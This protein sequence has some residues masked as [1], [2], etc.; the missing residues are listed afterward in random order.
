M[1]A[2]EQRCKT[3]CPVHDIKGESNVSDKTG[4]AMLSFAHVHANGY[5]EQI[6]NNPDAELVAVWD[7]DAARGKQEAER[8][9]V[10]FHPEL[11]ALLALDRVQGVVIDAP[12]QLHTMILIAAANAGK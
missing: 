5:A 4:L 1:S 9:G 6:K 3:C 2:K 12:T 8:R 7:E 11:D 10:P